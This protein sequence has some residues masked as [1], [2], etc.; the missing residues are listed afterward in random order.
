[1]LQ[2]PKVSSANGRLQ[3]PSSSLGMTGMGAKRASNIR[4]HLRHSA[5]RVSPFQEDMPGCGIPT[6]E[7]LADGE[8][9]SVLRDEVVEGRQRQAPTANGIKVDLVALDVVPCLTLVNQLTHRLFQ[10][11]FFRHS[12]G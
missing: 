9:V 6:C 2:A 8:L 3:A 10:R 1:M 5:R 11:L 7:R 12:H 4:P